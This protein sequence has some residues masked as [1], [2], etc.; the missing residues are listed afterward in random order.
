MSKSKSKTKWYVTHNGQ[1]VI[2]T[3]KADSPPPNTLD[4][5]FPSHDAALNTANRKQNILE[6]QPGHH[7]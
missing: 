6:H 1:G 4:G 5:P 3:V 7:L 2:K